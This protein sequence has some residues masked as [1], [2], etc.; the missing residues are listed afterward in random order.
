MCGGHVQE[1]YNLTGFVAHSTYVVLYICVRLSSGILS[2]VSALHIILTSV[3]SDAQTFHVSYFESTL[4]VRI[5]DTFTFV[6]HTTS[7][8]G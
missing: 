8:D 5:G 7:D 1:P 6:C 3:V 4:V 2:H